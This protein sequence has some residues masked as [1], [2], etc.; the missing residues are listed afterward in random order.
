M[1]RGITIPFQV[2]EIFSCALSVDV[3]A[4][5][6]VGSGHCDGIPNERAARDT[7]I[8]AIAE[9][10]VPAR[11]D[12]TSLCERHGAW[13]CDVRDAGV[14]LDPLADRSDLI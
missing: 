2:Q 5:I 9:Y 3:A 8:N 10:K 11:E 1:T 4:S 12:A 6:F 7:R 14:G 13:Y